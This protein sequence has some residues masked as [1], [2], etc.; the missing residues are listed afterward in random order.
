MLYLL[1]KFLGNG[2]KLE[3]FY[4]LSQKI[5]IYLL[6]IFKNNSKISY[7]KEFYLDESFI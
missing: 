5:Y 2:K 3:Y 4:G 7:R 6:A 1:H